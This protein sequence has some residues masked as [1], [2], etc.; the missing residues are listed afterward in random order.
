MR[1]AFLALVACACCGC[2]LFRKG[3]PEYYTPVVLGERV[4]IVHPGD[5]LVVPPL[6]QPAGTWFLVDDVGLSFWLGIPY[7]HIPTGQSAYDSAMR[8]LDDAEAVKEEMLRRLDGCRRDS[9]E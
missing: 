6:Q 7:N 8:D 1:T 5:T 4:R 2:A 9:R 3:E